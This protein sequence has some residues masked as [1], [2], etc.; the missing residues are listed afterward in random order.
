[1]AVSRDRRAAYDRA[2]EADREREA[3]EKAGPES[4]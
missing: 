3:L 2:R 4:A 1:M